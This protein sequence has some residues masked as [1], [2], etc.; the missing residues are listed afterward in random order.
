M[1]DL[2]LHSNKL[3]Q[4]KINQ[5]N[6]YKFLKKEKLQSHLLSSTTTTATATTTTTKTTTTA[7]RTPPPPPDLTLVVDSGQHP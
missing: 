6:V 5:L 1:T 2:K 4:R 3:I 7:T